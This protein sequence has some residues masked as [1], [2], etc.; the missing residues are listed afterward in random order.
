MEFIAFDLETTGF[1]PRMSQIVEI[2]AVKFNNEKVVDQFSTLINP[3]QPIPPEATR[4]HGITDEMVARSPKIEE[5]LEGF[6]TFCGE[7]VM[8]A[9]NA[10]F[11]TE[12]LKADIERFEAPAPRGLILDTC[13]MARKVVPGGPNYRLGTLVSHLGFAQDGAYH[14]AEADSRYCGLLF[15]HM[16]GRVFKSGEPVVIENL[17]NLSGGQGVKFP[18]VKRNFKQLDLFAEL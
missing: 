10:P 12:F 7:M 18:Q 15:A 17:I 4:V 6:A 9:H 8:V 2:A 16:L 5:V 3:G 13:A 1:M 11:D 14:R